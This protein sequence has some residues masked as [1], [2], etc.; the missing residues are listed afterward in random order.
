MF[1]GEVTDDTLLKID[2]QM[3]IAYDEAAR[4]SMNGA[5]KIKYL[6]VIKTEA[7]AKKGTGLWIMDSTV[8]DAL[9]NMNIDGYQRK[10][11]I[12]TILFTSVMIAGVFAYEHQQKMKYLLCSSDKGRKVLWRKK[13]VSACILTT[14]VWLI[15]YGFEILNTIE[16]YGS[17]HSLSAPIQSIMSEFPFGM[18]ILSYLVLMYLLRLLVL[19]T[20]SFMVLLVSNLC[21]KV[22]SAVIASLAIFS[23]P[24]AIAIMGGKIMEY[25]SIV[26]LLS[27]QEN[28]SSF[29]FSYTICLILGVVSLILNYLIWNTKIQK[30]R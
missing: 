18:S 6:S 13:T 5:T 7:Q 9:M 8:Y 29:I 22:N 4:G 23:L 27:P 20:L 25:F 28:M 10:I 30:N 24:A 14:V 1:T 16:V 21:S 2:E 12:I 15:I 17:L 26:R 3:E 19:L 11:G